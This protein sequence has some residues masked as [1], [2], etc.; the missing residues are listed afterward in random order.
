MKLYYSPGACSLS[1]HIVL[2]EAG[3]EATYVKVD[4]ANITLEGGGDYRR[5]NPNGYVPVL[6][7]DDGQTL[8]EGP[9]IV[10]YLADLVPAKQLVPQAGSLDRY[11]VLEWLNFISAELHKGFG[12]LF[13]T[14]IPRDCKALFR[15][16]LASRLEFLSGKL[17]DKPYLIGEQLTVADAYLYTVLRWTVYVNLDLSPWPNLAAYVDRVQTRPAVLAALAEEGLLP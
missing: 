10:Q 13:N 1:P 16:I 11:Y 14:K 12:V 15:E 5:V 4:L 2:K 6:E 8:M 7:F 9:A 17:A 3:L